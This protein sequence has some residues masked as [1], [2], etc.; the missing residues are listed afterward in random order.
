MTVS[1][2]WCSALLTWLTE[3]SVVVRCICS[4]WL[5][6][7][8]SLSVLESPKKLVCLSHAF[9]NVLGRV[10]NAVSTQSCKIACLSAHYHQYASQEQWQTWWFIWL[11]LNTQSKSIILY[12]DFLLI[13]ILKNSILKDTLPCF[14]DLMQL[15]YFTHICINF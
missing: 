5:T 4:L 15:C 2:D 12:K 3:L 10:K 14:S 11:P 9:S 8:Q 7:G 6:V 13:L 1:S